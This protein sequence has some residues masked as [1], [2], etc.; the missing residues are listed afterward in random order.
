MIESLLKQFLGSGAAGEA[1]SA[2]QQQGLNETQAKSAVGAT[3]EGAAQALSSEGVDLGS[4]LAGLTGEGG[5]GALVGALGKGG[6]TSGAGG[7][8]AQLVD[9]ITRVVA[10]KTGIGAATANT[11]V[12]VVMPKILAFVKA[13]LG[14]GG[15][16]GD[17]GLLGGLFGK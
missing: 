6:A 12:N 2:L 9:T 15:A 5:L 1:V 10:E 13:K 4:L 8:P 16:G 11:V 14:S 3:A 17:G 7:L